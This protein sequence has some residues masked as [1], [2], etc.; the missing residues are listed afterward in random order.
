MFPPFGNSRGC[1]QTL[2][3][4]RYFNMY[5]AFSKGDKRATLFF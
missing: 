3:Y 5:V 2:S 1:G 4:I